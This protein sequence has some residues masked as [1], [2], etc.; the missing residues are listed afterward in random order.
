MV[1]RVPKQ[2]FDIILKFGGG[3]NTRTPADQINEREIALG[4]NFALDLDDFDLRPRLPFDL[5]GTVPNA[6]IIYGFAQLIDRDGKISTLVQGG[7]TVYQWDGENAFTSVGSVNSGTRIRGTLDANT[8]DDICL[9]ADLGKKTELLE[10]DGTNLT[11]AVMSTGQQFFTKYAH[12]AHDRAFYSNVISGIDVPSV[13]AASAVNDHRDITIEL[14]PNESRGEDDS[15]F[16]TAPDGRPINGSLEAFGRTIFSSNGGRIYQLTG[17]NTQDFSIESLFPRSSASGDEPIVFTGSDVLY[18][19]R[20]RIESLIG[21]QN[22]GDVELDDPSRQIFPSIKN[23]KSWD[24]NFDPLRKIAYCWPEGQATVWVF[25]SSVKN[26]SPWSPWIT[27]HAN[28]FI[29][30]ASM[31]MINPVTGLDDVFWG[32][33]T[34]KIFRMQGAGAGD[35]GTTDIVTQTISKVFSAPLDALAYDVEGY[36]RYNPVAHP[37]TFDISILWGGTKILETEAH[38]VAVK[39]PDGAIYYSN[40]AYYSGNSYYGSTFGGKFIRER[41]TPR[42]SSE[43]LQIQIEATTSSTFE[44]NEIGLRFKASS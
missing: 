27:D 43:E 35:G 38:S 36:V 7:T 9:V 29:K 33:S 17:S 6:G 10:W 26:R 20:G 21:T 2:D 13:I 42:G 1:T 11:A 24:I 31:S 40:Q 34:G 30:T 41:F 23:V 25:Y 3:L 18:G 5:A 16:I 4:K 14:G 37:V 32:D 15:F 44:I 12:V 19:R 8:F 22:F 28:E 39:K